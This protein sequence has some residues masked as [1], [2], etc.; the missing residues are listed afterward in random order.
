MSDPGKS[1]YFK[2]RMSVHG[3]GSVAEFLRMLMDFSVEGISQNIKMP[4]FICAAEYDPSASQSQMLY[5]NI[6]S[7]D[8]TLTIFKGEDGA[9]D[10][11][12]FAN[13][14]I[15]YSAVFNWLDERIK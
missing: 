6:S 7:K 15:F 12:E 4:A 13:Q 11:C 3:A 5:D 9:G 14:D 8:K 2:S 10:H 1:F